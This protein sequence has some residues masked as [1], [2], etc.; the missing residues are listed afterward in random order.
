MNI[1]LFQVLVCCLAS[2]GFCS[3]LQND[4]PSTFDSFTED[5]LY[6]I[7]QYF[8]IPQKEMGFL[9]RACRDT[10]FVKYPLKKIISGRFG[11]LELESV[12][13][14]DDLIAF[15]CLSLTTVDSYHRFQAIVFSL[16]RQNAFPYNAKIISRHVLKAFTSLS[17][18]LKA[19]LDPIAEIALRAYSINDFDL[20]VELFSVYPSRFEAFFETLLTG[21]SF[22]SF[23]FI[24]HVVTQSN[25]NELYPKLFNSLQ[26]NHSA[27]FLS[28][29]VLVGGSENLYWEFL[30]GSAVVATKTMVF[31][32]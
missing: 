25:I 31:F 11:I 32:F 7:G 12:E 20:L 15:K 2:I 1:F 3:E 16:L 30:T 22:K 29:S 14:E 6:Y 4:S 24:K 5:I 17:G 8:L 13:R 9:N 26:E 23:D 27:L 10:F 18:E 19:N 21:V 28:Y